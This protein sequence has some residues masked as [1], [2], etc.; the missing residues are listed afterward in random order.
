MFF[1]SVISFLS[2][3]VLTSS[4]LSLFLHLFFLSTRSNNSKSDVKELRIVYQSIDKIDMCIRTIFE[5]SGRNIHNYQELCKEYKHVLSNSFLFHYRPFLSDLYNR[6][7]LRVP[8]DVG[9]EVLS[10]LP[11][12]YLSVLRRISYSNS[13]LHRYKKYLVRQGILK[14]PTFSFL[15]GFFSCYKNVT[16]KTRA[17]F[18]T[19]KV[20]RNTTLDFIPHGFSFYQNTTTY[21]L[22]FYLFLYSYL[23]LRKNVQC[24]TLST[25]SRISLFS[26]YSLHFLNSLTNT[27]TSTVFLYSFLSR[28]PSLYKTRSQLRVSSHSNLKR[29]YLNIRPFFH[30]DSIVFLKH[31]SHGIKRIP[32]LSNVNVACA[33]Y[34][35]PCYSVF[36]RNLSQHFHFISLESTFERPIIRTDN[37]ST[38][39][40]AQSSN[41]TRTV[42][43]SLS[44]L[45]SALPRVMPMSFV[46]KAR[47]YFSL[48]RRRYQKK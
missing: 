35:G 30:G 16:W 24:D 32:F 15:D 6:T 38:R 5:L 39:L 34:N 40:L 14:I 23:F 48:S 41:I 27:V 25:L 37:L 10:H 13:K 4:R 8:S 3:R 46:K 42:D 33:K 29:D 28:I 7:L 45:E 47:K 36:F 22:I 11:I 31:I 19:L 1:N 44:G 18:R 9:S 17:F 26:G 2:L 43:N 12:K 21:V 20:L